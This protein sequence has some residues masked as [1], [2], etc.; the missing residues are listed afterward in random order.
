MMEM[1]TRLSFPVYKAVNSLFI[2][3]LVLANPLLVLP[4]LVPAGMANESSV[5]AGDKASP[6]NIYGN[7]NDN[8]QI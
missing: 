6:I 7:D 4:S 8:Q 3:R 2:L 1:I 5:M